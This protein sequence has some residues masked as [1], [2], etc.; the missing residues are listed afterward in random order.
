MYDRP[1]N[2]AAHDAL[3]ACIRDALRRRGQPAPETLTRDLPTL[4]GWLHPALTL[5][6]ACNLPMRTTLLGRVAYVA[7]FDYALPDTAPGYYFSH[8]VTRRGDSRQIAEHAH[9]RFAYNETDSHS[10]WAAP[11]IAAAALGFRFAPSL[12]TGSHRASA[13]ALA[14]GRADIAAIDAI[15]W[16]AITRWDPEVA[17]RLQIIGATAPS[18]G[19]A[20][21][22][23][24]GADPDPLRAALAEAIAVMPPEARATLGLTGLTQIPLTATL[25]LQTPPTPSEMRDTPATAIR[26]NG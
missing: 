7:T 3:W 22:T 4:A 24:A 25:A 13:R 9:R 20:L 17:A 21:I 11:Q 2:A 15:S 10:G 23:A 18:P 1:E 8:F 5:G 12:A 6:Q 19:Q 16:R 26:S 14:E